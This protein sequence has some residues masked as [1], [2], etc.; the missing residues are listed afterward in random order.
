MR[1]FVAGATGAIG[2]QLVPRL[3]AAGHEVVGMTH[4]ESKRA[5]LRELGAEPVVA[6][7]LD[8][9]QVAEAVARARPEV[10]SRLEPR[11]KGLG[12][13]RHG[14]HATSSMLPRPEEKCDRAR[15]A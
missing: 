15:G 14:G 2:K 12:I 1:V 6:D 10:S 9:D 5:L 13:P 8:P 4:S 11:E 3:V 7:A